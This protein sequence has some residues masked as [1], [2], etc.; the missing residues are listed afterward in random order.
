MLAAHFSAFGLTNAYWNVW[1]N[2]KISI[3]KPHW[4]I[5]F[6]PIV[7]QIFQELCHSTQLFKTT[8][9]STASFG[10]RES[11]RLH[12]LEP[13]TKISIFCF[14]IVSNFSSLELP[15]GV[16]RGA[17]RGDGQ[18]HLG[19]T[20]YILPLEIGKIVEEIWCFLPEV[21]TFRKEA[22]LRAIFSKKIVKKV[23]FPQRFWSK[24]Q[25][26]W[27]F[28]FTFGPNAQCFAGSLVSLAFQWKSFRSPWW[29]CIFR[30][31]S[32]DFLHEFQ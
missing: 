3:L 13:L 25:K 28:L 2:F 14:I 1:E 31:I 22:E 18:Y 29:S 8:Q 27:N 11:F 32:V 7:Y 19:R 21:D 10:L 4:K 17:S 30:Q 12:P 6:L 5:Y 24:N 26:L 16:I 15:R 9:F 20:P 23:N